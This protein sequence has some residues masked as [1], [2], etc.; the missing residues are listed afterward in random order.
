M[1]ADL[2]MGKLNVNVWTL[3]Y[4]MDNVT[5]IRAVSTID[6]GG[7]CMIFSVE[8]EPANGRTV[9]DQLRSREHWRSRVTRLT[10]GGPNVSRERH[11]IP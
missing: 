1:A 8:Q 3:C 5:F 4:N 11:A 2:T 6:L 10:N 7:F 9:W